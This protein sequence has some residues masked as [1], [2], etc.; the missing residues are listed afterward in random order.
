MT[1][2]VG[3]LIAEVLA[4]NAHR[5]L[6]LLSNGKSVTKLGGTAFGALAVTTKFMSE[7][8][9][10]LLLIQMQMLEFPVVQL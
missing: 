10:V 2:A 4:V 6:V 1:P 8:L 5:W 9:N 3:P 7:T